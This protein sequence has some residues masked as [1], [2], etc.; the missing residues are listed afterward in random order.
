MVDKLGPGEAA[1]PD[2]YAP[3]SPD[4]SDADARDREG[5]PQ[6]GPYRAGKLARQ[7]ARTGG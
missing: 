4:A 5:R 7:A 6:G 3:S 2:P 1:M